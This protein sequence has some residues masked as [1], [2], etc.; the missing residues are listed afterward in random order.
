MSKNEIEL[1]KHLIKLIH[2]LKDKAGLNDDEEYRFVLKQRYG[3][4]SSK[5]LS[6]EE[7]RDFALSLGYKEKS[8]KHFHKSKALKAPEKATQKQLDMIES[9]WNKYSRTKSR[10]ALIKFILNI[11]NKFVPN[12]CL[13]SK[14][15]A[16]NIIQG[17]KNLEKRALQGKE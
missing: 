10:I 15:D 8:F 5:D 6:L 14:T 2:I 17:L 7:L 1:K 16:S 4:S 9:L 3:K 12:L 13:L 11:T